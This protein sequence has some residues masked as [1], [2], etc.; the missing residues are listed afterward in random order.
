M[1]RVN[2]SSVFL[3][4]GTIAGLARAVAE[5]GYLQKVAAEPRLRRLVPV[6]IVAFLLAAWTG[7][8]IQMNNARSEAVMSAQVEMDLMA[9][10]AAIDLSIELAS[11]APA[12]SADV[13]AHLEAALPA[14][15]LDNNRVAYVTGADGRIAGATVRSRVGRSLESLLGPAQ[16]LI[17]LADRAGVMRITLADGADALAT[18]RNLPGQRGQLAFVQPVWDATRQ[19]RDRAISLSLLAFAPVYKSAIGFAAILLVLTFRPSGL[20]GQRTA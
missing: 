11:A 13:S 3:R 18:V 12:A 20:L 16:P 14:H 8:A 1:A 7:A 17:A 9:A 6:L 4:T 10:L 15:S 2:A 19:W 5:P